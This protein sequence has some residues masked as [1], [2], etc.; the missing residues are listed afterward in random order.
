MSRISCVCHSA[1]GPGCCWRL[2]S[3]IKAIGLVYMYWYLI[4]SPKVVDTDLVSVHVISLSSSNIWLWNTALLETLATL[5]LNKT[6][7]YSKPTKR[8]VGLLDEC[9]IVLL[10]FLSRFF[11]PISYPARL[12]YFSGRFSPFNSLRTLRNIAELTKAGLQ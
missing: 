2:A 4:E 3:S 1:D 7:S 10:P 6:D 11:V 8:K 5:S 12:N 9:V